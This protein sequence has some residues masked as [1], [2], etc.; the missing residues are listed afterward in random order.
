MTF[1][2]FILDTEEIA[3]IEKAINDRGN[4]AVVIRV[5]NGKL[6][7]FTIDTKLISKK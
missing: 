2:K 4:K 7:I 3:K 1:I 5:E 6:A